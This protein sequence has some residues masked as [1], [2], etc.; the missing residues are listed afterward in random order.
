MEKSGI[1]RVLSL[2][3]FIFVSFQCIP[4]IKSK[5]KFIRFMEIDFVHFIL[6]N[7]IKL[8]SHY[9]EDALGFVLIL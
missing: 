9:V 5:I 4:L 1:W 6:D 7:L 2:G 8:E 3:Y